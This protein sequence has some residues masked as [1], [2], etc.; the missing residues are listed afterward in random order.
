M[1]VSANVP[2]CLRARSG[3]TLRL[4]QQKVQHRADAHAGVPQADRHA[5]PER[6]GDDDRVGPGDRVL[7]DADDHAPAANRPWTGPASVSPV[8]TRSSAGRRPGPST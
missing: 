7:A 1:P 8:L 6:V 2:G 5:A 4:R 3:F